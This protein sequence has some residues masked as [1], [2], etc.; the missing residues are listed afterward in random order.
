ME[1]V[2]ENPDNDVTDNKGG[3]VERGVHGG[4]RG[5]KLHI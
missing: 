1:L 3:V 4:V 2:F 5:R